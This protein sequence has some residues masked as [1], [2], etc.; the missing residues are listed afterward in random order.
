MVTQS[1]VEE[2]VLTQ[3][4]SNTGSNYSTSINVKR[5]VMFVLSVHHSIPRECNIIDAQ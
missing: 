1:L 5:A 4:V 3:L 2:L